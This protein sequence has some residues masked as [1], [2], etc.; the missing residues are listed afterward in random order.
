MSSTLLKDLYN[1]LFL[2]DFLVKYAKF[3]RGLVE[4]RFI[5]NSV[6]LQNNRKI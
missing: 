5:S 1:E 3:Y 4:D 2:G 6:L